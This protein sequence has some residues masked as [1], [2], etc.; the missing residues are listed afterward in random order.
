M[1]DRYLDYI[2]VDS[3]EREEFDTG[4]VRD[5]QEGKPRYDLIPPGPL[6]RLADLYARG[7]EKYDEHNWAKGQPVSRFLASAMRH[8]E[9][10]RTGDK[11]EDH[12][13]AVVWNVMAIMHF[14]G[15]SFDD[16]HD[17]GGDG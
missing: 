3:G 17:W 4:S 14:E 1:A 10:A 9:A 13:A 16:L 12:W 2:T 11:V 8:L 5:T 7:A 6:R 15:T